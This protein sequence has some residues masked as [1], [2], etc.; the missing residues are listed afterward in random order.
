MFALQLHMEMQQSMKQLSAIQSELRGNI[1]FMN[2]G[3]N[4]AHFLVL[5]H[6]IGL[7]CT[8]YLDVYCFHQPLPC[9]ICTMI[10]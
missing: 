6:V 8:S 7:D 4:I 2:P 10:A 5:G 3:Y 9:H 1:N